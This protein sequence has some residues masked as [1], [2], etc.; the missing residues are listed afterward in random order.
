MITENNSSHY[1]GTNQSVPL[2]SELRQTLTAQPSLQTGEYIVHI[3]NA[4]VIQVPIEGPAS[5]ILR[6]KSFEVYS[7]NKK[8][9]KFF[10]L[11]FSQNYYEPLDLK[12]TSL[13]PEHVISF[14]AMLQLQ[15]HWRWSIWAHT[16]SGGCYW[17][18]SKFNGPCHRSN[19]KWNLNG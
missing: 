3:T 13:S 15:K 2:E 5:V 12:K 7:Q 11:L 10:P 18:I 14:H 6:R 9:A 19:R 16:Q 4:N 1:E 8:K 17:S